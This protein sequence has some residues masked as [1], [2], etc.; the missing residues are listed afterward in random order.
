MTV[1]SGN[2]TNTVTL[3]HLNG[4]AGATGIPDTAI[5]GTGTHVWTPH[6]DFKISTATYSLG[7]AAGV[8]NGT[9]AYGD[10]PWSTDFNFGTGAFTIDFLVRF[11]ALPASGYQYALIGYCDSTN[12]NRL[13][14]YLYNSSGTYIL[15]F[16]AR[17]G[18]VTKGQYHVNWTPSLGTWYHV[19]IVRNGS[20]FYMMQAGNNPTLSV[21][22]AISTNSL[23]PSTATGCT[24]EFGHQIYTATGLFGGYIDEVR[25]SNGI[26]R[27][28]ATFTPPVA[29]YGRGLTTSF[30][31][32]TTLSDARTSKPK[33]IKTDILTLADA[34][35]SSP[36]LLKTDILSLVESVS[37]KPR[38]VK[39][40]SMSLGEAI[41]KRPKP[42]K[43]DSISLSESITK[44]PRLS[45]ADSITVSDAIV[46]SLHI[47][48]ADIISLTDSI[49]KKFNLN[50]SDVI[51]LLDFF[52][53]V[54]H[55]V[56]ITLSLSDSIY[57]SDVI[58]KAPHLFKADALT[59]L[60]QAIKQ[61]RLK[62]Q[63]VIY[64]SDLFLRSARPSAGAIFEFVHKKRMGYKG[65]PG[66]NFGF[67]QTKRIMQQ[68]ETGGDFSFV[69]KKRSK[70]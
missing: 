65:E 9:S 45:K 11:N 28:T 38:L 7:G 64:L 66:T 1:A 50:K 63:D 60:D 20:S 10:T 53:Y 41:I 29:E 44:K 22:T 68:G 6:G 32:S 69:H 61:T 43:S 31:D 30:A 17:V 25:I 8:L 62:K 42:V 58:K 33:P 15:Y 3:L 51:T 39:S 27:W 36:K 40:D 24:M 35:T 12:T 18:S 57:L 49:S 2:D 14:I 34:R 47:K 59:I 37:K 26:A 5:G 4:S 52:S 67:I 54:L 70:N 56:A 48:K 23:T 46:K 55:V 21:D 19:A 13:N 16:L